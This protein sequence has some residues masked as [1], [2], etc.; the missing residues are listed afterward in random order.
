ME[1]KQTLH[2]KLK[3]IGGIMVIPI[4]F[5]MMGYSLMY[6]IGRPVIQFATTSLQLFLLS[7]VPNHERKMQILFHDSKMEKQS[8]GV[9][10]DIIPSSKINYPRSGYQYGKVAIDSVKLDALLYYG[11]SAEILRK[12]VGHYSGSVYPGELG[13]TL[14]GGH[15]TAEFGKMIGVQVTDK[16]NVITNYGE[17]IYQVY[18]VTVLDKDDHRISQLLAQ[19]KKAEL[20]L[21]TCYPVDSIGLTNQRLFILCNLIKGPMIQLNN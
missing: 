18:D 10:N 19:K 1:R 7:D 9:E 13:T 21:Y 14:I 12:G 11:D 16:V 6:I 8:L 15:N 3:R 5:L 4:L 17:Y 2:K 20:V